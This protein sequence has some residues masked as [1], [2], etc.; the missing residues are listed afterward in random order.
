MMGAIEPDPYLTC[1]IIPES[2]QNTD[3]LFSWEKWWIDAAHC[4]GDGD[5]A[6]VEMNTPQRCYPDDLQ[7]GGGSFKA[8]LFPF[9]LL[10][11]MHGLHILPSLAH[12]LS[13]FFCRYPDGKYL[14]A[15][16]LDL[17]WQEFFWYPIVLANTTKLFGGEEP[18]AYATIDAGEIV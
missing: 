2:V 13:C 16:A 12:M 9:P 15:G 17:W 5:E 11:S 4:L 1:V 14:E 8:N 18:G 3:M 10:L 6:F 7:S